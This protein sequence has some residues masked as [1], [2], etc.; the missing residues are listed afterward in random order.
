MQSS[1]IFTIGGSMS[2]NVHGRD[3]NEGPLI[4]TIAS[5]R[6]MN[7]QGR[8]IQVSRTE[9]A[10]W[11]PLVVGGYG[12][13]GIVLDADIRLTDDEEYVEQTT[14]LTVEQFPNYFTQNVKN[15]LEI[16]LT[17]ARIST[18]PSS[19][20]QEMYVTVYK[21]TNMPLSNKKHEL[22]EEQNIERNKFL[23]G[24]LRKFNWGKDFSWSL[25]KK[26]LYP[27]N[28][29]TIISRNNAMRPEVKFL[30][31][32]NGQRTDILQEYFVPLDQFVPFVQQFKKIVIENELN[33]I[34]ITVRYVP[35]N[36]EALLSYAKKDCFS[37]AFLFNMK[38][39]SHGIAHMKHATRKI[40][41]LALQH[42][43]TYY[44]TYQLFPSNKQLYI[45]Y[46]EAKLFFLCKKKLDPHLLF[47]NEFYARY[48]Q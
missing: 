35:K 6:L 29:H 5:F 18:A 3:P 32:N 30:D 17:F 20:L 9:N 13:F 43:G 12:L 15:N 24:L 28:T 44:L 11:F 27:E 36:K 48:T 21:K 33:L 41:D 46:P 4:D 34:N 38:R 45:A 1:N 7:A 19:F 23:F 26:L 39:S 31:Y 8:I 10:E 2:A 42:N 14:S 37:F 16:G 47:M 22:K 25:Q 40:V